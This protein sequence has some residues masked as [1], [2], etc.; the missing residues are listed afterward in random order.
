MTEE[1]VTINVSDLMNFPPTFGSAYEDAYNFKFKPK[2]L[3]A[4]LK[5]FNP[6]SNLLD[7]P[8][9]ALLKRIINKAND[10]FGPAEVLIFAES[11][12][13]K[14]EISHLIR[15]SFMR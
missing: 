14:E 11:D 9:K 10:P 2:S 4:C 5:K 6:F 7:T 8:E 3:L 15:R 1:T 12:N 13:P